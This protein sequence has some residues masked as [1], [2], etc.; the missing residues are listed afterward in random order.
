MEELELHVLWFQQDGATCYTVRVILDLLRGEF[1][2]HFISRSGPVNWPYDLKPLDYFLWGY[3]KA[4]VYLDKAA[5]IH[6]LRD[7]IEAF[8][9]ELPAEMLKEYAKI[10]LSGWTIWGAFDICMK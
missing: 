6:A 5:S 8:I 4:H 3:V 10:R 9:P 7:N 1:G 2:E